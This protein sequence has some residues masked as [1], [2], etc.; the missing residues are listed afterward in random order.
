M[1]CAKH[2]LEQWQMRDK[3]ENR[4]EGRTESRNRKPKAGT[5]AESVPDRAF[6]ALFQAGIRALFKL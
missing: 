3:S 1:M 4:S 2:W 6:F 5:K